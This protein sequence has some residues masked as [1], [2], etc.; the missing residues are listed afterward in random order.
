MLLSDQG[1][2]RPGLTVLRAPRTPVV[3]VHRL[4]ST[5]FLLP[6]G[7][8]RSRQAEAWTRA[9]WEASIGSQ[10]RG[11]GTLHLLSLGL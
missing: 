2:A 7:D 5:D 1:A 11:L 9:P 4:L 3:R 10:G 6:A 8:R